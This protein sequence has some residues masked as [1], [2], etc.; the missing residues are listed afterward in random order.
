MDFSRN[1]Q[2]KNILYKF[3]SPKKYSYNNPVLGI[4]QAFNDIQVSWR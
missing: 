3:S 4:N 1:I 2:A